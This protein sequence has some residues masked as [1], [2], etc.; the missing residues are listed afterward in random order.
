MTPIGVIF[1]LLEI[2]NLSYFQANERNWKKN[3]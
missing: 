3:N 2:D 1:R